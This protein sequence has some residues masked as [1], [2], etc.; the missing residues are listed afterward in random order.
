MFDAVRTGGLVVAFG[1]GTLA[2]GLAF[3]ADK[4]RQPGNIGV[5]LGL[6]SEGV[7]VSGKYFVD[8]RNAF[9]GLLG[10]P[11][12][13]GGLLA[14]FD[15]LYNFPILWSDEKVALGWYAGFGG[16]LVTQSPFV[17]LGGTG[18]VGLDLDVDAAPLDIFIELKPTLWLTPLGYLDLN[19]AGGIRYYF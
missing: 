9:Q 16:M 7:G 14:Q 5:G 19:A 2:P 17:A 15:Y 4:V 8:D 1:V 10:V 12:G 6:T 18:S 11:N 3:G 13:S